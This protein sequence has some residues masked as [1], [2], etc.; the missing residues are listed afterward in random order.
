MTS[1]E[2][3]N[4]SATHSSQNGQFPRL[5]NRAE[6]YTGQNETQHP[7]PKKQTSETE[8]ARFAKP[9]SRQLN[10]T[11]RVQQTAAGYKLSEI[12]KLSRA[13]AH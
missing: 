9:Q 5:Y 10:F 12:G 7:R 11:T 4:F 3:L 6:A 8:R 13:Q 1:S 2:Q